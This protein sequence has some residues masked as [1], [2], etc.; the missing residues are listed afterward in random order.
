[1]CVAYQIAVS[2]EPLVPNMIPH[3]TTSRTIKIFYLLCNFPPRKCRQ[4]SRYFTSQDWRGCCNWLAWSRAICSLA[5]FLFSAHAA[6]AVA[7]SNALIVR[8]SW[9][10]SHF[11]VKFSR[12]F[13]LTHSVALYFSVTSLLHNVALYLRVTTLLQMRLNIFV[14]FGEGS[15]SLSTRL[16][17][18]SNLML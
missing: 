2:Y 9:A 12:W 5:D 17:W 16:R 13:W 4:V 6:F 11:L 1:M 14:D 7:L 8:W 3:K 18:K 15:K 10:I